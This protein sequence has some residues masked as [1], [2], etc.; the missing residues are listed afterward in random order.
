MPNG[1]EIKPGV[2]FID[3]RSNY[4]NDPDWARVEAELLAGEPANGLPSFGPS[5]NL[6]WPMV[7]MLFYSQR[8][9]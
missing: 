4:R 8:M 7:F 9:M 3:I 1:D 5:V 2:K 6:Q